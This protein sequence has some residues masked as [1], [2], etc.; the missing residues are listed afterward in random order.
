MV[1]GREGDI[2]KEGYGLDDLEE[3]GG[4]WIV[5]VRVNRSW[6]VSTSSG[7]LS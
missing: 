6:A 3:S 7:S 4:I 5:Y 1:R 2:L